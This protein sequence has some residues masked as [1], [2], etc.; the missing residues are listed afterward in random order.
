MGARSAPL[1][2]KAHLP[3]LLADAHRP[4]VTETVTES[5]DLAFLIRSWSLPDRDVTRAP[6]ARA[7]Y[8]PG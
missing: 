2:R 8:P 3:L 7:Q 1:L 4:G 5:P 6:L